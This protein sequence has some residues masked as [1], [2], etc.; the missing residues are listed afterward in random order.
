MD[1]SSLAST[2]D[3]TV[4]KPDSTLDNVRTLVHEAIT[5]RF[6]SVCILPWHVADA[7]LIRGAHPL[8]I[9]TV[10]GF[11]LGASATT[12]KVYEAVES[13]KNGASEI[14]MVASITA[15]KSGQRDRLFADI[16]DVT[17]A[18]HD[19]GAIVKVIIE[20][21]LLTNEEKL[22]MC[23]AVTEAGADFIKTSTGFSTG[24]ATL[25]DVRLLRLHVGPNVQVKASGG[26]RD[27]A[28]AVAMINAG[29]TR[30]GTSSG[31]GIVSEGRRDGSTEVLKY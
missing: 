8:P 6:A 2:I 14:D 9:C 5:H 19:H 7:A 1:V 27:A 13:I 3:H 29:A 15:L 20:T 16:R 11:P 24:G 21:C 12:T 23:E 10:I 18:V 30:L 22:L 26:I 25:D 28:T 4:L 17:S 31:V